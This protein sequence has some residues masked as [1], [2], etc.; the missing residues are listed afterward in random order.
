MPILS[1]SPPFYKRIVLQLFPTKS[2]NSSSHWSP[3]SVISPF[4]PSFLL[5]I[6]FLNAGFSTV[7]HL[8]LFHSESACA[9]FILL[10]HNLIN[11]KL[12]NLTMQR[13]GGFRL[14]PKNQAKSSPSCYDI[15]KQLRQSRRKGTEYCRKAKGNSSSD[16]DKTLP[17]V[18]R[19]WEF[20]VPLQAL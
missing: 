14:I 7:Y 9:H 4:S 17:K 11:F 1:H 12:L 10:C 2:V 16:S 5:L 19:Y 3:L 6:R 13:Y 8:Q 15:P 18:W 20:A